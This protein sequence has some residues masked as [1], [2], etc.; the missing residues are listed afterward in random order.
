M[1]QFWSYGPPDSDQHFCVPRRE[2][3]EQCVQQLLGAPGK[4]GHFFTLWAPRQT[5]KTWVMEQAVSEIR[6][7][8]GS[9]FCIGQTSMQGIFMEENDPPDAFLGKIPALLWGAFR[10]EVA[11]PPRE[12]E[13]LSTLFDREK[14]L[15]DRPVVL[16]IDEFDGLPKA[17]IDRLVA[18]FRDLYLKR[19]DSVLHGLALVGV[20]AVLG[21]DSARGSPFNI[22]RSLHIPNLAKDEVADLFRQYQE[23]SGQAVEPE[24]VHEAHRVT[25]GQPGLVGWFGELLTTKHNPG[26][27]KPLDMQAWRRTYMRACRVE[28]NNTILNLLKKA[29]TQPYRNWVVELFS[30]SDLEFALD[31]DWCNYLY[32]NGIIDGELA[33]NESGQETMVCRFSSPFIQERLYNALTGDLVGERLPMLALD[34]L[35]DLA[36]VF[37]EDELDLPALL[38]RYKRFLA[39]LTAE[40]LNPWKDQP[41]RQDLR[42]T[43]AVGH[44]HLYAW[45][46][47]AVGRRCV[48]SPE[49]PTG[50]G[51]VDLHL[52][53]GDRRGIIEV[54]SFADLYE[55][56]RSRLQAAR[57]ATSLGFGSVTLALF[58]P[59]KDEQTLAKLS[60]TES[61][62]GAQVHTIA[63]GWE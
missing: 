42:M 49:F 16:L 15:F 13:Q 41:T 29:R 62:E 40:G 51:K 14:G 19:R 43:E 17:V 6:R 30:A 11:E 27:D 32:L 59:T 10:V 57:Y 46:Q 61:L 56:N 44:F 24:V 48:A 9:E 38:E 55:L 22:Q 23:E 26:V 8:H 58:V 1:R 25:R 4:P 2:L 60:T 28:W 5:G 3:V 63:I 53:C 47:S 12:W 54:K 39:R 20:R 33:T 35:D 18:F 31:A 50:N 21:L 36:D 52:R 34:P 37:A 7:R 45:L